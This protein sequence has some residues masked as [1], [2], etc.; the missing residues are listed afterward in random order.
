MHI[1]LKLRKNTIDFRRQEN[2]LYEFY[3][4]QY[5]VDIGKVVVISVN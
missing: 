2:V 4:N 1:F 5:N 3:K